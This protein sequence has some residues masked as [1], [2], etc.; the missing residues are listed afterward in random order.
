M[1]R[2]L[3]SAIACASARLDQ[4][5]AAPACSS[6]LSSR[7]ALGD[8][9]QRS[10]AALAVILAVSGIYGLMALFVSRRRREIGVRMALGAEGRDVLRLVLRQGL[11]L[12]GLGMAFGLVGMIASATILRHLLYGISP[13]EPTVVVSGAALMVAVGLL[14]SLVPALRATHLNNPAAALRSDT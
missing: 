11:R 12:L 1:A 4:A 8:V 9:R 3:R 5:S 10:F 2:S 6:V 7:M 14:G 13:F